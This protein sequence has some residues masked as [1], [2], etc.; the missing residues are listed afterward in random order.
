VLQ[1][2]GMEICHIFANSRWAILPTLQLAESE[3]LGISQQ[4]SNTL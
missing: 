1:R 2:K 3:C 4:L